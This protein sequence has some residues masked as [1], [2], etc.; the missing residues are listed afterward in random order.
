ME[1]LIKNIGLALLF[2]V[3]VL[4]LVNI[5]VIMPLMRMTPVQ[6]T[7]ISTEEAQE[8]AEQDDVIV[9]VD[10]LAV[11]KKNG[12]GEG[13]IYIDAEDKNLRNPFFWPGKK[14]QQRKKVKQ[15][16]KQPRLSMVIIG[17]GRKQALLDDAFVRE[18]DMYHGYL[19]KRIEEHQVILVD[20]LGEL[21][22]HLAANAEKNGQVQPPPIIIER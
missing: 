9:A 10:T 19:V 8:R 22:I 1:R 21:R 6:T 2:L 17:E 7:S 11:I 18:G 16:P 4:I 15:E 5:F 20:E 3:V 14:F 13:A 12:I